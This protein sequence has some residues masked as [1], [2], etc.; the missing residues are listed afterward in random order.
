MLAN[1]AKAVTNETLRK[2]NPA[3]R[4][5]GPWGARRAIDP[6][7]E[8]HPVPPKIQ[9][10]RSQSSFAAP[11]DAMEGRTNTFLRCG[12]VGRCQPGGPAPVH[13]FTH[14]LHPGQAGSCQ[15]QK[16]L[17]IPLAHKPANFSPSTRMDTASAFSA[18]G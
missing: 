10:L 9:A 11:T 8:A 17:P 16:H 1:Q 5:A 14:A 15:R 2:P 18:S 3:E 7:R 12:E 6:W 13:P 4:A